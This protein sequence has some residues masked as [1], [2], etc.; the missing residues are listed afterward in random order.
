MTLDRALVLDNRKQEYC[1]SIRLS[2]YRPRRLRCHI[3]IPDFIAPPSMF[4]Y[5][6]CL[7]SMQRIIQRQTPVPLLMIPSIVFQ[8]HSRSRQLP[9]MIV[10]VLP[11]ELVFLVC[12][13]QRLVETTSLLGRL[14][15]GLLTSLHGRTDKTCAGG[16]VADDI[17]P[18]RR[19]G[20]SFCVEELGG[21]LVHVL[22]GEVVAA[23]SEDNEFFGR[24][25]S[26]RR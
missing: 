15:T 20:Y 23:H 16:G 10:E 26:S 17:V 19:S 22:G 4:I 6:S 13:V 12:N 9:G 7:R 5:L 18:R 8:H 2:V 1:S 11:P 21:L 14:H 24:L 25:L 3:P